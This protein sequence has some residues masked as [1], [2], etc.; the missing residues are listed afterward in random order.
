VPDV[1]E[2]VVNFA[3][4]TARVVFGGSG[5]TAAGSAQLV[6]AVEK[7]GF[8]AV[9]RTPSDF[10]PEGAVDLLKQAELK[11]ARFRW[12]VAL[13]GFLPLALLSMSAHAGLWVGLAHIPGAWL[14]EAVVSGLVVLWAGA[15]ILRAAFSSVLR[16]S[17]DMDTLVGGGAILAWGGSV[18]ES[19]NGG[20]HHGSYFE[21]AAGIVTFA[22]LGRWLE[23]MA[24]SSAG[25][26]IQSLAELQPGTAFV[27]RDGVRVEV[28]IREVQQ[29]MI[30]QVA[31][32]ERI[33]VDG[34]I[35]EGDSFVDESWVTGESIPVKR[36]A[37]DAV[38]G[39][40]INGAGAL[41]VRVMATGRDAFLQ[42]VVAIVREAQSTK[43]PIQRLADVVSGQFSLGVLGV[44]VLTVT[45][46]WWWGEGPLALKNAFWHGLSVLVVA[47]PCAL[48]LA[49]PVAVLVGSGTAAKRGIL[50]RSGAALESLSK[51]KQS[52]FDKT[53]TLTVGRMEVVEWWERELFHRQVL[54]WVAAA[55]EKSAHP[56]AR[57][58]LYSAKK[59]G[60]RIS[61]DV[62]SVEAVPG[63]GIKA[64]VEGRTL[65]IGNVNLMQVSGVVLP[66]PSHLPH[67]E[68]IWVAVDGEFAAWFR[69]ADRMREEAPEVVEALKGLGIRSILLTGDHAQV[70]ASIA[71]AVG[72][73]EVRAG[74]RPDG[75]RDAVME[76]QKAGGPVLMVG[77]GI[78]DA[79]ALAQADVGVAMGGGT[80][81]ARQT[82]DVTLMRDD[83][84]SLV[85]AIDLSKRTLRVIRQNLVFAFGYNVLALP[86][87]AGVTESL[88]WSPGPV[89]ASAAMALS[90]VSVVLNALRLRVPREFRVH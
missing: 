65:L 71:E 16:L 89:V 6:S 72:I 5:D 38:V 60:V 18:L 19:L 15:G 33:A 13:S 29:G 80:A 86:L 82:A 88:G 24:R 73:L 69:V 1:Q 67:E 42:Q 20:G 70:A 2:A 54:G 27:E 68:K 47:C 77:D 12:L 62:T 76:L 49:T 4:A 17:P 46:W 3:T 8:H 35:V 50:F 83:L 90:S 28:P 41:R 32:G 10:E 31:P 14:G 45:V 85:E 48:G 11:L 39:G 64:V 51:V 57:A 61:R 55:E 34:E 84:R 22:L 78:N 44:A 7:A 26:A 81:V 66:E 25:A 36:K 30:V 63:T 58:V 23:A 43:P 74:V 53:G 37:G 9:I 75:K 79:P 59:D 87:A 21:A 56:I 52:V 40:T